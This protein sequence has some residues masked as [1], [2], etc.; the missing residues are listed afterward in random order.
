[1]A[2][3]GTD[4]GSRDKR[5]TL[6]AFAGFPVTPQV[7]ECVRLISA[8]RGMSMS[9]VYRQAIK[10]YVAGVVSELEAVP[11]GA[12]GQ[13]DAELAAALRAALT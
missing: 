1:M 3:N 6:T 11:A 9:S 7:A 4:Q 5:G 12:P 10:Q 2:E 13:G 8:H